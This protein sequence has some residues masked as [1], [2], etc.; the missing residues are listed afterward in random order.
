MK[1]FSG[2]QVVLLLCCYKKRRFECRRYWNWTVVNYVLP[3]LKVRLQIILLKIYIFIY[4]ISVIL[5]PVL[6]LCTIWMEVMVQL[7]IQLVIFRIE[8]KAMEIDRYLILRSDLWCLNCQKN[9]NTSLVFSSAT[10][11]KLNGRW[12]TISWRKSSSV[13]SYNDGWLFHVPMGGSLLVYII[14]LIDLNN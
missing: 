11:M 6:V 14:L 7:R 10:N 1:H 9:G 8:R 2:S 12:S 5:L 4:F 13:I 3:H